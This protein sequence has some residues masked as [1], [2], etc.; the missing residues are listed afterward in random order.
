MLETVLPFV[1]TFVDLSTNHNKT[2]I[3]TLVHLRYIEVNT[4]LMRGMGQ[5]VCNK[6]EPDSLARGES[7]Q[8]GAG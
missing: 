7:V 2:E 1:E 5:R 4:D 8:N 3:M 6:K